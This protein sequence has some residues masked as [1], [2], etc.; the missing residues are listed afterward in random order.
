MNEIEEKKYVIK[1]QKE[2]KKKNKGKT[3]KEKSKGW[4]SVKRK[5]RN[6]ERMKE[7]KQ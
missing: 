3:K 4:N 7:E 5:D 1:E 6:N 2:K